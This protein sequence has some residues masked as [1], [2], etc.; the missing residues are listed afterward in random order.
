M[1]HTMPNSLCPTMV[2]VNLGSDA[3]KLYKIQNSNYS[4]WRKEIHHTMPNSLCPTMVEV[5]LG[6]DP[7][8]LYKIQNSNYSFGERKCTTPC[9]TAMSNY[10][11]GESG[12]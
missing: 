9:R 7:I 8:N 4:Y 12:F 10:G 3:A 2:E 1:H 11:Q 5:N 6:S